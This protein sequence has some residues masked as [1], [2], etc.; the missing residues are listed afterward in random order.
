MLLIGACQDIPA[1]HSAGREKER[2]TEER[3]GRITSQN[4]RA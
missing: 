1:R 2:Q 3:D 4:G